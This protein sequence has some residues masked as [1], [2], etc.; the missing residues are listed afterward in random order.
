MMLSLLRRYNQ[1]VFNASGGKTAVGLFGAHA[2]GGGGVGSFPWSI[3]G[4]LGQLSQPGWYG[5]VSPTYACLYGPILF[6]VSLRLS[7]LAQHNTANLQSM[8]DA[9][10]A[11]KRALGHGPQASRLIPWLTV[12]TSGPTTP[13]SCFDELVH[14]F[15]NGAS[16]FS[17]YADIDFHDMEYYVRIA[18]VMALVTPFEDLIV[19]GQIVPLAGA[20]NC[21]VSAMTLDGVYLLGVTPID[22]DQSVSW[23]LQTNATGEHA[24]RDVA[25]DA[26]VKTTVGGEVSLLTRITQTTVY[27]YGL[28][29]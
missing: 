22:T 11:E 15:L 14:V 12:D 7:N 26:V 13:T 16:G 23:T 29:S 10:Q 27:S 24:L 20:T 5:Q 4:D 19:D 18:E 17:Y 25:R 9:L 28:M 21:I 8:V 1:T 2:T 3:L 6:R